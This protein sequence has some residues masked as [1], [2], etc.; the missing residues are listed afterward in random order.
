MKNSRIQKFTLLV[1]SLLVLVVAIPVAAS[2][3]GE[4]RELKEEVKVLQQGQEQM[5]K[6]LTEIKKLLEQGAKAAPA[7]TARTPFEAKDLEV[8]KSAFQGNADATVT[9]FAYSDYQCPYC[10]RH[11]TMVMPQVVKEYVDSGKLRLVMREYPIET[12]HPRAFAA[13]QAALCAGT[14]GKYWEMHDLIFANQKA[15]SDDELKSHAQTLELDAA[16]F[17]ACLSDEE[18]DNRI[19]AEIQEAQSMGITGTPSF[20]IG[21]TDP[22]DSNEV[23]VTQYI[24]GA[25]PFT[26]FQGAI[27]SLL[28]EAAEAE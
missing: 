3:A 21:L 24:R 23:R 22:E 27:D 9:L 28:K 5:Q 11:A 2:T 14:K 8:G 12:I 7:P 17:E 26:A 10:R 20:V 15:L 6:D 16:G 25:Q 18:T 1:F 4:V 13:A 19:R